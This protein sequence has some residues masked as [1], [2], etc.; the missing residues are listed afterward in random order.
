MIKNLKLVAKRLRRAKRQ[1][2]E[3]EINYFGA[4]LSD[5]DKKALIAFLKT[6]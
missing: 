6:F 2:V 4:N 1:K 3:R 5:A